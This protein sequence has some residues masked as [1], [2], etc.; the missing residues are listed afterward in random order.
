V[1]R[2][3]LVHTSMVV[4][5]MAASWFQCALRNVDHVV[6]RLRSGAG[7]MPCPFKMLPTVWSDTLC[8]DVGQGVGDPVV[9]PGRIL[10]GQLQ[11]PVNDFLRRCWPAHRTTLVAM[12]PLLR[13]QLPMPAQN[14]V[15]R[16]QRTDLVQELATQDLAFDG[17]AAPLIVVEQDPFLA[18]LLLEH[19]VFRA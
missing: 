2:P 16:E 19:L 10:A 17:Q 13:H 11:D 9:T 4:K 7:S 12:V 15:R 14:G 5:S 6:V 3:F 1:T 18:V 8:P